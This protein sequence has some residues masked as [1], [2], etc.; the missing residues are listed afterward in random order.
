MKNKLWIGLAIMLVLIGASLVGVFR[1]H[2]DI[3]MMLW[4]LVG[5]TVVYLAYLF[6]SHVTTPK[7]VVT[8]STL[9]ELKSPPRVLKHFK[10]YKLKISFQK[11]I[12]AKGES[13]TVKM[14]ELSISFN[15]KDHP[16]AYAYC[17][18][19]IQRH[20]ASSIDSARIVHP[21][22]EIIESQILLPPEI[23][24]LKGRD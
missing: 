6:M 8:I 23:M 7:K 9:I 3:A 20:M 12:E 2:L 5:F 15:E 21:E 10:N 1:F 22:A 13:R 19:L 16:D 4:A 17:L 24:R 11:H 14:D 18:E